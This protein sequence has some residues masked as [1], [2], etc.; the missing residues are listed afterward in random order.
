M[1]KNLPALFSILVVASFA[2]TA[3]GGTVPTAT[4]I[5]AVATKSLRQQQQSSLQVDTITRFNYQHGYDWSGES[6]WRAA[7]IASFRDTAI[8][9]G[10]K[11]KFYDSAA[12][13]RKL[14]ALMTSNMLL[15]TPK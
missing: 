11:L 13:P 2:L 7:N 9:L 6:L 10:V 8:A 4:A 3:C 1:K 12:R 14:S 5:P 15:M